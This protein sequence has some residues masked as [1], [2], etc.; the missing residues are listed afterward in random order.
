MIVSI[1]EARVHDT[2]V[3]IHR[4][5]RIKALCKIGIRA[6]LHDARTRNRHR[7]RTINPPLRIHGDDLAVVNEKIACIAVHTAV[8]QEGR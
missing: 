2:V 5:R 6:N 7:P 1:D 4:L 3:G 8:L